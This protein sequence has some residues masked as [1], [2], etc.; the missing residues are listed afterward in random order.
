[1]VFN[2]GNILLIGSVLLFVSM[3]V[4][5]TGYK[6]GVPSL[7][8][9][10]I[11]G[12]V[13][14]SD[15]LGIQ[16]H[17][18]HEAQFIGVVSLCIILFAGGMDTKMKDIRPIIGPGIVLSTIG[19]LLTTFLTGLFVYWITGLLFPAVVTTLVG[20]LL[21]AAVMSST[22]SA[23][24]FNILR[25]KDLNL[26]HNLR[27]M[28]E[29]ESGSND[30]MAYMLTILL[31]QIILSGEMSWSRILLSFFTQFS[32]G[33]VLGYLLGRLA[34]YTINHLPLQNHSL[35]QVILLTF[36]F[37]TFSFTEL[38]YGNGYLAVYIAGLV[39]G[40]HRIIFKKNISNFFDGLAWLF[41]I[42]MFL[43]LG[44]LVNPK[45]L[46]H[47]SLIGTLIGLFLI[48][49]ARPLS[50]YLCLLPFRKITPQG[51]LFISWVGL[52]GAVPIIFATYPLLAGIPGSEQIFN[53]VFF[54]TILSLVLQGTT[55]AVI[56]NFLGLASPAEKKLKEF[57][58]EFPD[59]IKSVVSEVVV[60]SSNFVEGSCLTE[61]GLPDN[62]LVVMIKRYD[63]Y[64]VPD[65]KTRLLDG[66]KLLILSDNE[67]QLKK[68]YT[69][70]GIEDYTIYRN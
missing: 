56:A 42:I 35:Y 17:N 14:G 52:R 23:S 8:L 30:P 9:F 19:V 16:F 59:E 5:K 58:V 28:L 44:L 54:I 53:V 40:N 6:L 69:H 43:A 47:V 20:S 68:M 37:F 1:M 48:F 26:R 45:D 38:V 13:F 7:L 63:H 25:S 65:G 31:I 64:F 61:L 12:M 4:G 3:I 18:A 57:G 49:V 24:V 50:V 60:T 11:V 34:V 70:L 10:L 55:I 29:L 36:A 39:V 2:S 15:G 66:D 21:L 41:Q 51:R 62:T 67:E 32:V 22:D 46:L 33:G 27:P